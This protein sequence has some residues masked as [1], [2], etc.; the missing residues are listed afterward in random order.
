MEK[1]ISFRGQSYVDCPES[2]FHIKNIEWADAW[3]GKDSSELPGT[4]T[5]EKIANDQI[6]NEVDLIEY[7]RIR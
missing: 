6:K 1:L 7:L 5:H 2:R 3:M 4:L